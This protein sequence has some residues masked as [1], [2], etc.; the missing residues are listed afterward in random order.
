MFLVT[1]KT[2]SNIYTAGGKGPLPS[3][4][5][6]KITKAARVQKACDRCRNK[7]VKCDGDQPCLRCAQDEVLCVTSKK[8]HTDP[9]GALRE[10][11]LSMEMQQT[12]LIKALKKMSRHERQPIEEEDMKEIVQTVRAC[13][14]DFEG[15]SEF[16]DRNTKNGSTEAKHEEIEHAPTCKA[17]NSTQHNVTG[18]NSTDGVEKGGQ[19]PS[20]ENS[21]RSSS[22]KRKRGGQGQKSNNLVVPH[23][24]G[25]EVDLTQD[26]VSFGDAGLNQ[27]CEEGM[28]SSKRQKSGIP[29]EPIDDYWNLDHYWEQVKSPYTQSQS[30]MVSEVPVS[31]QLTE[32]SLPNTSISFPQWP[33]PLPSWMSDGVS[34][35]ILERTSNGVPDS[36][37]NGPLNG[38]SQPMKTAVQ[39]ETQSPDANSPSAFQFEELGPLSSTLE[40]PLDWQ[41]G[42]WW[43]PSLL[44]DLRL[45]QAGLETADLASQ[46]SNFT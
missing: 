16:L 11:I 25:T 32:T 3:Q 46:P 18:K 12:R 27:T 41:S 17:R 44:F 43:D 9:K 21:G 40:A 24:D 36:M 7:K 31:S 38:I 6:A 45:E 35:G 14:F 13:G 8:T 28:A 4:P 29:T 34:N 26:D 10:H 22:G 37:P 39:Y 33:S 1:P 42:M 5:V 15:V 23:D 19:R 20:I 2:K 30:A